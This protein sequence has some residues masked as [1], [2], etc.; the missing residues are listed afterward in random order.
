M[1][2]RAFFEFSYLQRTHHLH[3]ICPKKLRKD[4]IKGKRLSS[5]RRNLPKTTPYSHCISVKFLAPFSLS[6]SPSL[7][8]IWVVPSVSHKPSWIQLNHAIRLDLFQLPMKWS[9]GNSPSN[10]ASRSMHR[11]GI[12][13]LCLFWLNMNSFFLFQ[14]SIKSILTVILNA[15]KEREDHTP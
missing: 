15:L 14:K 3:R 7:C 4:K 1:N 13:C 2:K 10:K 8:V 12:S 9:T 11:Q 6:V 5:S